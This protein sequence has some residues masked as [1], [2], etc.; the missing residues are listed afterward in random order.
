MSKKAALPIAL[1]LFVIIAFVLIQMQADAGIWRQDVIWLNTSATEPPGET[2]QINWNS[3]DGTMNIHTGEPG[4]VV[5]VGLE[6]MLYALNDS[7]DDIT[8]G[9]VVRA[10]G[11]QGGQI[12]IEKA[13]A[14]DPSKC[15][16]LA[17]ATQD[18]DD[19]DVGYITVLGRVRGLV[20]TGY[21]AGDPVYLSTTPG[22][23]TASMPAAP[24][25]KAL[26]GRVERVG[27]GNGVI[28]V[29]P[30]FFHGLS[31]ATDVSLSS[32][33]GDQ[34]LVYNSGS[35]VFENRNL[36]GINYHEQGDP[37]APSEGMALVYLQNGT[38]SRGDAGD[39]IAVS[40]EAGS[41]TYTII[42]DHSVGTA[43]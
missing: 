23:Y 36:G 26:I 1:I 20:T 15:T 21:T 33:D 14:T 35:S 31:F 38:G 5:Q 12:T 32:I 39:L 42:H 37:S 4:V 40:T 22:A 19:G 10:T 9:D 2:G 30:T 28:F 17:M 41:T 18:I 27:D 43:W 11:A 7:G 29:R 8:N 34:I 13:D 25:A 6:T 24:N 16:C 3:E